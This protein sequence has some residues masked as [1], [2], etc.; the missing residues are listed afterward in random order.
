MFISK[1]S[2]RLGDT[3][4]LGH[5]NNCAVAEWFE[6]ARQ[7]LFDVFINDP[8]LAAQDWHLIMAHSDY[9]FLAQMR[10]PFEVEIHT[11]VSKI[12][13]SSFTL[14]HDI[15]QKGV[16]TVHGRC[17][18]VYF[19]FKAERSMRLPDDLRAKLQEHLEPELKD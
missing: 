1:I 9:D 3:D 17:V 2:P 8:N 7:P 12:G 18:L 15:Y 4:C 5:I 19:D 16:H 13:N 10:F 11:T 14:S 6:S